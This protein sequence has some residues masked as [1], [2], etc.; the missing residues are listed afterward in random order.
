VTVSYVFLCSEKEQ[1]M[2]EIRFASK[3]QEYFFF[4]MLAKCGNSDSY[5]RAFFYCVGISDTTRGN[6]ERLFDFQNAKDF[7]AY[8]KKASGEGHSRFTQLHRK[9]AVTLGKIAK[10]RRQFFISHMVVQI[11]TMIGLYGWVYALSCAAEDRMGERDG[12]KYEVYIDDAVYALSRLC[13][14]RKKAL[15]GKWE[16]W[17]DN[18]ALMNLEEA[19]GITERLHLGLPAGLSYM[20]AR[21]SR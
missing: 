19:L 12:Q 10:E 2:S 14:D 6:V 20:K 11:E 16:H 21:D 7:I 5:H 18:D 8:Y 1:N 3:E 9:A 17:Y 15:T 4:S 13:I